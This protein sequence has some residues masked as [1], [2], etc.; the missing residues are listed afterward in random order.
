MVSNITEFIFGAIGLIL[1]LG[2]LFEA[3]RYLKGHPQA[4]ANLEAKVK[5]AEVKAEGLS[6]DAIAAI[7]A[8]LD[9]ISTKVDATHAAALAPVTVTVVPATPTPAPPAAVVGGPSGSLGTTSQVPTGQPAPAQAPVLVAP[10][11]GK[12]AFNSFD[13]SWG[14]DSFPVNKPVAITL[15]GAPA[16]QGCVL[17]WYEVVGGQPCMMAV[18]ATRNGSVLD[19]PNSSGAG[20]GGMA[21]VPPGSVGDVVVLTLTAPIN[22]AWGIAVKP[23]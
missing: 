12:Y 3:W 9:S 16:E 19:V 13:G 8:K 2:V 11:Q 1:L 7:H 14:Y 5:A 23:A 21:Q 4:L 6:K 15:T 10:G 22:T 18:S 17:G 20:N